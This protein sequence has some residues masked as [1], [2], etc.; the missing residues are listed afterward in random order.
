MQGG[1]VEGSKVATFYHLQVCKPSIVLYPQTY[2]DGAFPAAPSSND[3]IAEVRQQCLLDMPVEFLFY[4]L[5]GKFPGLLYVACRR[6]DW[7]AGHIR[8]LLFTLICLR[9]SFDGLYRWPGG[10]SFSNFHLWFDGWRC[11]Y[12]RRVMALNFQ[13]KLFQAYSRRF[14]I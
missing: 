11:L 9:W 7:L 8:Y 1:T 10:R 5:A 4:L 13:H 3:G 12:A 6:G 2:S 14:C